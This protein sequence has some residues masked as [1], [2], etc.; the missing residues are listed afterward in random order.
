ML[1]RL[2]PGVLKTRPDGLK[3]FRTLTG[4]SPRIIEN[5]L[6]CEL[7]KHDP[8]S[9]VQSRLEI[10]G[11]FFVSLVTPLIPQVRFFQ[12]GTAVGSSVLFSTFPSIAENRDWGLPTGLTSIT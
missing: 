8:M 1:L 4:A 7:R 9:D 5:R 2:A 12:S 3:Q 11:Y 10:V 6:Q